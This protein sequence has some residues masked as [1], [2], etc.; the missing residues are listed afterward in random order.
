MFYRPGLF[1]PAESQ[2]LLNALTDTIL[3]ERPNF[4]IYG[5]EFPVPRMTAWYGDVEYKYS[6]I[7]NVPLPWTE[8]LFLIKVRAEL[9]C[10]HE[11]NSVLLNFYRDGNDHMSWHS[12]DEKSLGIDPVIA[13]VSFGEV[14]KF[15]VKHRKDKTLKPITLELDSGSLVIMKGEMQKFWHHRIN[16]SKRPMGPR[17]NLTFRKVIS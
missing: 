4:R 5:K 12:D 17:I 9:A 13:S 16:P 6:G 2:S 15:S 11:F 1:D 7:I 14:R 8:E 10:A 3:W